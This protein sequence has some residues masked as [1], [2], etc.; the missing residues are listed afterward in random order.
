MKVA[1]VALAVAAS[2]AIAAVCSTSIIVGALIPL[3]TQVDPCSTDSNVN[4]IEVAT[5]A[6]V[7]ST[8]QL[9]SIQES[10]A[11]K[12]LYGLLA[13]NLATI[14]P[15]CTL[16]GISTDKFTATP[17]D[18]AIMALLTLTN[19]TVSTNNTSAAS[20]TGG[21]SSTVTKP[22]TTATVIITTAAPKPSSAVVAASLSLAA[23]GLAL[24]I[25]A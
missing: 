10:N 16:T 23:V 15:P 21:S 11:C 22:V 13:T 25:A 12:A 17:I 7:P 3:A 9:S 19:P 14:S 6:T 8:A 24:Y 4:L 5:T 20:S 2:S 1:A 18:R